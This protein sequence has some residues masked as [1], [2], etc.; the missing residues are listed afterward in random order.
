MANIFLKIILRY[1]DRLHPAYLTLRVKR[2]KAWVSGR[3][4]LAALLGKETSPLLRGRASQKA[5]KVRH[6]LALC[7]QKIFLL[8]PTLGCR[9]AAIAGDCKSPVF[10]HRRFESYRPNKLCFRSSVD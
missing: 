4:R 8:P 2:K 7:L 1:A 9:I 6:R 5:P 3:N 10:G